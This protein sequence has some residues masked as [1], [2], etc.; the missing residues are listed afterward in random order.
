[1]VKRR[2]N[3]STQIYRQQKSVATTKSGTLLDLEAADSDGAVAKPSLFNV[4]ATAEESTC[5]DNDRRDDEASDCKQPPI[6]VEIDDDG[7]MT[8]IA[9]NTSDDAGSTTD[10]ANVNDLCKGETNARISNDTAAHDTANEMDSF[11][12]AKNY[13]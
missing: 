8:I 2:V 12:F 10:A 9:D 1:M 11:A 13:E 5:C 6:M 3:L 4:I 7:P